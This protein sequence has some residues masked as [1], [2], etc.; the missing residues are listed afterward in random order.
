[1][2]ETPTSSDYIEVKRRKQMDVCH[3][4]PNSSEF[5]MN[6]QYLNL[7]TTVVY[8]GYGELIETDRFK[9]PLPSNDLATVCFPMRQEKYVKYTR[10]RL[11]PMPLYWYKPKS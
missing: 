7:Q 3:P 9:I 8:D 2:V 6:K 1:M 4:P 10:K 11:P 5:T